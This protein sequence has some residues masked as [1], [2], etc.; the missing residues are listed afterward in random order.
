MSP[1][2]ESGRSSDSVAAAGAVRTS[3]SSV[4]WPASSFTSRVIFSRRS[5]RPTDT[6][7]STATARGPTRN[8]VAVSDSASPSKPLAAPST[9]PSQ[10]SRPPSSE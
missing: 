10:S 2:S 9:P 8:A 1:R 6:T 3:R 4:R 7:R 5:S